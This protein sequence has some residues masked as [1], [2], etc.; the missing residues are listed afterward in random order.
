MPNDQPKNPLVALNEF[1]QVRQAALIAALPAHVP[2][3][4]FKRTVITA[5]SQNPELLNADRRSLWNA[6]MKAATDGLPP[7]GRY[8]ALVPFKGQVQYMPMVMGVIQRVRN[9]G[10][11]DYINAK[12]VY[13][14]DT[15]E[16]YIDDRGE[17]FKHIPA[18]PKDGGD[19][20][21]VYAIARD[22]AGNSY[23]EI[24]TKAQVERVRQSS[25]A[26]N[27]TPWTQWWDEMARKT[28]IRR[29]AKKLP[30]TTDIDAIGRDDTDGDSAEPDALPYVQ[31]PPLDMPIMEERVPEPAPPQA[32]QA[33][34]RAVPA[35]SPAPPEPKTAASQ[36]P[37]ADLSDAQ[38]VVAEFSRQIDDATDKS[39]LKIVWEE[40]DRAD[41]F[42]VD[43][44]ALKMRAQA[45]QAAL[46][47]AR[48]G[49]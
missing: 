15:I 14:N 6:C 39:A 16:H 37:A 34:E 48:A 12:V 5:V 44:D 43:K 4:R 9:S 3:E 35:P 22:K 36:A 26:R 18:W 8:A 46:N 47:I 24:M 21:G 41:L 45:K 19:I 20:V 17:H 31:E 7:D 32:P 13:A 11:V 27:A 29:L 28:V 42:P 40:I 33:G 10:A 49:R 30:A 2:V 23:I 38:I 25:H 1:L